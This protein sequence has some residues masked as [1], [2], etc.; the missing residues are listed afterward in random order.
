[1]RPLGLPGQSRTRN[2]DGVLGTP[3][4]IGR[5]RLWVAPLRWRPIHIR[6]VA[7]TTAPKHGI[8]RVARPAIGA[9]DYLAA[10]GSRIADPAEL[11]RIRRLAIPPAWTDV[12][13][14]DQPEARL[15]ATGRDRRGRKQYRYHPAFRRARESVKFESLLEFGAVLPK[16]RRTVDRDLRRRDLPREKVLATT[17]A[18]LEATR[19]RIGNRKYAEA[20]H[21]Y[22][23]TTLRPQQVVVEG[24]TVRFVFRGK[25]GRRH[26]LE[27]HD[28]RLARV[29]GRCR[30]APGRELFQYETAA[31][32]W[33][34]IRSDDINAYLRSITGRDVTAK[35]I[36]TWAASVLALRALQAAA[37]AEAASPRSV[38]G[39][40]IKTVA[41]ALGNTPPVTR[42]S[43][44]HPEVIDWYLDGGSEAG[45]DLTPSPRGSRWLS[46]D[47]RRLIALLENGRPG[48]PGRT[49][50]LSRPRKHRRKAVTS[51]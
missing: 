44:I 9:F 12:W 19:I 2:L 25:S 21:S 43:Y 11:D 26:R 34:A 10:D 1:M 14:S 35:T 18:I 47:E 5:H 28:R 20:N 33:V 6:K 36:R 37:P 50:E 30:A 31:G 48:R 22:G 42:A 32:E 46:A 40:A 41:A 29:V 49:S 4:S 45:A 24:S 8:S 15:Q 17:V 3:S 51:S 16:L 13:I 23:L 27:L 7:A 39:Q 38:L